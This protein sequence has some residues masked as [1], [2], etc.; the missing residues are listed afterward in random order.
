MPRGE[1]LRIALLAPAMVHWSRNGW[2]T[3]ED[4]STRDTGIGIHFA[5]LPTSELYP[6]HGVVFTFYW[7]QAQRWEGADFAVTIEAE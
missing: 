2:Q 3:A 4:T 1:S 6:G 7:Q 5:D